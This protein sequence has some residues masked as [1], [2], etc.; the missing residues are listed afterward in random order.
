[1]IAF[2]AAAITYATLMPLMPP[3]L[4]LADFDATFSLFHC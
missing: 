2:D 3:L 1:M 4:P